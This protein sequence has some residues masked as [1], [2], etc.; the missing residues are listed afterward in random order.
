MPLREPPIPHSITLATSEEDRGAETFTAIL[1]TALNH[2]V[3][4][5]GDLKT[6]IAGYP[7]FLDWGRDAL[8]F[9][10]GLVAARKMADAR[11]IVIQFAR[12]E[13]QVSVPNMIQAENAANRDTSDAPLWL[14]SACADLVRAEDDEQFIDS[15]CGGRSMRQILLSIGQSIKAGTLN[16]V[17][18]D[19]ESGLIF[20]PTHFSWMDTNHP[21]GTPDRAIP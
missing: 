17:H 6:V 3:V 10:R 18:M 4:K 13:K 9:V 15:D 11:D 7:W 8:I 14:I 16:G 2:Y 1:K 21:A 20:S 5:R 12:F 19:P